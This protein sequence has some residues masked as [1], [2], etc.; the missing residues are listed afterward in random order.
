[1]PAPVG[2]DAQKRLERNR[3]RTDLLNS[4]AK[5]SRA[6]VH[7]E[8]LE[9]CRRRH[10]ILD[11]AEIYCRAAPAAVRVQQPSTGQP[12]RARYS[13]ILVDLALST[14]LGIDALKRHISEI[15]TGNSRHHSKERGDVL[16]FAGDAMLVLFPV[17]AG[18][19]G[20]HSQAAL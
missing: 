6:S 17:A 2:D 12:Q 18:D 10:L 13:L 5:F 15:Y 9:V 20:W 14:S 19:E 3:N 7:A 16:K 4:F 1:M 8:L 11:R